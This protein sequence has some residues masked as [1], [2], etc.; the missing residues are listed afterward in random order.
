M[1]F[2]CMKALATLAKAGPEYAKARGARCL[3]GEQIKITRAEVMSKSQ[4]QAANAREQEALCSQEYRA[5]VEAWARAVEVEEGLRRKMAT[6][7]AAI[8][9]FRTLEASNRRMDK[10]A[11]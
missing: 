11:A 3:L 1:E 4:A 8:E 7:E 10:G 9:L 5:A 2:D 6:A